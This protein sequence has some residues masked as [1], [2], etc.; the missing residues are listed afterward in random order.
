MDLVGNMLLNHLNEDYSDVLVATR[1]RPPM[2]RRLTRQRSEIGGQELEIQQSDFRTKL[3][4][5]DRVLNRFWD[6]PRF[7]RRLK[8]EFDLFHVVDHSYSQLLHELPPER[9]I[10][11]CHDLDTFQ[12]LLEP[13]QDPRSLWFKKMMERTLSGF[14]RAARITCDS[15]ATRRQLLAYDLVPSER[16]AVVPNGVHPS[17]S[18]AADAPA[19]AKAAAL[20]GAAGEDQLNILHV[21]ST[22]PRKRIDVLL[23]V[24][25]NLAEKLPSARLLRVGGNFT[26]E[27]LAL[28]G[29]LKVRESILILPRV[30]NDVLA[31]LYRR[32]AVLL[33]PSERE[34]FGLPVV[35]ALACGTPVVASDLTVLREVGADAALYCPVANIASWSEAVINL[36]REKHAQ[37]AIWSDRLQR[38]LNQAAKFSWAE[39]AKRMVELYRELL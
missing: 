38:G 1:I 2:R 6:Y 20:I 32:A 9:T 23:R 7:A 18:P 10:V 13:E 35:E 24:F 21:G 3:F 36:L 27:Q 22:I 37:P 12:C 5:A 14:R 16:T 31:A 33:Q 29:Q 39:Y 17:C 30:D 34:G 8:N 11:T 28:A 4:N 26:A 15:A 19:D 25:A